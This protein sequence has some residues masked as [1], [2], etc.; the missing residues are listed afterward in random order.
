VPTAL[1]AQD[2][3][4][5]HSYAAN[6][7]ALVMS[8]NWQALAAEYAPDAVRMPPNQPSIE[9]RD[10]IRRWLE[11]LPPINRF[12]FRLQDLRGNGEFACMRGAY[13]I[14]VALPDGTTVSDFGKT[15]LAFQKQ[16]D[17]S[18]LCVADIWNSDLPLPQ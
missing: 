10:E 7:A 9:G 5:L 16:P 8:R 3:A 1:S 14:E 13:S 12:S 2:L 6:D 17:G 15:L 11:Q 18:W 4:A